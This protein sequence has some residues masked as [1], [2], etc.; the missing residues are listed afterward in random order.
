MDWPTSAVIMT[1]IIGAISAMVGLL[2]K[3]NGN[4]NIKE[5]QDLF[6]KI[7]ILETYQVTFEKNFSEFKKDVKDDLKSISEK[8]DFLKD[9]IMQQK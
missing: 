9:M 6:S 2:K 4:N 5:K 8:I 7:A 3:K 1:A